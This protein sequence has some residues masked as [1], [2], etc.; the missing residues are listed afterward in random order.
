MV[1]ERKGKMAFAVSYFS[2]FTRRHIPGGEQQQRFVGFQLF[3]GV[4]GFRPPNE[5]LFRQSFLRQPVSLAVVIQQTDR[6][7]AAAAKYKYAA[8]KWILGELVLTKTHE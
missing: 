7:S 3:G 2:A 8:G 5:A 4:A 6:G 1:L